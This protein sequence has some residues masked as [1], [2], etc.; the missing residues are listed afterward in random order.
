MARNFQPAVP[1]NVPMKLLIPMGSSVYGAGKKTFPA[2]SDVSD[3]YLF[4][5]SVR[6]FGGTENFKDG[7]YTIINTATIE[8]WY[9]PDI[10]SDCRICLCETGEVYDVMADPED[11]NFRHQYLRL[12]VRKVGGKP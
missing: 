1:F 9:R 8:T 4:Y 2:P 11:I 5:G 10:K 3:D 6:S 12:K 7:V